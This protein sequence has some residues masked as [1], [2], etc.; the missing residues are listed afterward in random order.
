MRRQH[1]AQAL[2]VFVVLVLLQGDVER[3]LGHGEAHS[4]E[5]LRLPD[6]QHELFG[7]VHRDGRPLELGRP[8]VSAQLASLVLGAEDR[9]FQQLGRRRTHRL[10]PFIE[11]RELVVAHRLRQRDELQGH[12]LPLLGRL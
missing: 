6:Q 2:N 9:L 3:R 10:L 11:E 7:E 5:V 8:L 12:L 4:V 1:V